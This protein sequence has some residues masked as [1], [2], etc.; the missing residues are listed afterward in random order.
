[1]KAIEPK[2]TALFGSVPSGKAS[3]TVNIQGHGKVSL[4]PHKN[5]YDIAS[6]GGVPLTLVRPGQTVA[7]ESPEQAAAAD[8]SVE[9]TLNGQQ[10]MSSDATFLAFDK[11]EVHVSEL[12]PPAP[13]LRPLTQ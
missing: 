4:D 7:F 3:L 1:M 13:S 11:A 8:L 10:Y 6:K 5:L 9:V 12:V 2:F